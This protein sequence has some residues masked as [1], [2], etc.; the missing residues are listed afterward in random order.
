MKKFIVIFLIIIGLGFGALYLVRSGLYPMAILN[1][2][3]V[4]GHEVNKGAKVAVHYYQQ[5]LIASG[6]KDN[7]EVDYQKVKTAVLEGIFEKI[8]ISTALKQKMNNTDLVASVNETVGKYSSKTNLEEASLALYGLNLADFYEL[9]I[10]P[11]A[12]KELL[13]KELLKEGIS[14]ADWLSQARKSSKVILL[15]KEF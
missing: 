1:S 12:Q 10:V 9:V 4:W 7:Q 13:E 8:L 2:E 6:Q 3:V 11:Q 5:S 14:Y 15:T